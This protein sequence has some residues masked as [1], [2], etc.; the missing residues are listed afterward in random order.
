MDLRVIILLVCLIALVSAKIHRFSLKKRSRRTQKFPHI[1]QLRIDR[2]ELRSKF[3]FTPL[4]TVNAVEETSDGSG[5][6][7][8]AEAL[9]NSY[10][11]N[12][13][14][15][16]NIDGQE[17]TVQ[18][19]T[20]SSDCWVPSRHC[21]FCKK[22]CGNSV[23]QESKSKHFRRMSRPFSITYG[24]GS[25]KGMVHSDVLTIGDLKIENQGLGFVNSSTT[26]SVFDGICGMAFP[27]LSRTK[28]TPIVQNMIAQNLLKQPV[29]SFYMK[30]GSS[31]G[32]S[33]I[34]GGTNSSLH[35]GPLTYTNVTE[36]KYWT[37]HMDFIGIHDSD[38]KRC[39]SGCKAI[40]DS[41]TSLIAGPAADIVHL[42]EAIGAQYDSTY[43]LWTVNCSEI[44]KLPN[45]EIGIED[46]VFYIK[47]QTY[48]IV[49][50]DICLSGFMDMRGLTYWILGDVFM[51]DNY[52]VFD[53]ENK[54]IGIA[55]A[56]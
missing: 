49:Y 47:P 46:K 41:G 1:K 51:R 3:G 19:D 8:I 2:N 16:I 40:L 26:C 45:A 15:V 53:V 22:T 37:F 35:Y 13:Y 9:V 10:D 39:P 28:S 7:V 12:I 17:F 6:A 38:T 21:T 44:E 11:T 32:G 56:V 55:P 54:R 14:G 4:R 34:L 43:D 20:G 42:N 52:S 50:E 48:V 29:F 24:S 31:D 33:L 30:S 18:F 25:V 36:D 27:A 23:F 5:G